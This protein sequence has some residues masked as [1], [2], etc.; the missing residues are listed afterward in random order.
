MIVTGVTD[1]SFRAAIDAYGQ[2]SCQRVVHMRTYED[3]SESLPG[4]RARKAVIDARF[5]SSADAT[6]LIRA[7]DICAF[8]LTL[9]LIVDLSPRELLE[10]PR[11]LEAKAHVR[12]V[13]PRLH[14]L[15][16]QLD[17]TGPRG[18]PSATLHILRSI[19]HRVPSES[20]TLTLA[21]CIMGERPATIPR[22][23]RGIGLS[24]EAA[25]RAWPVAEHCSRARQKALIRIGHVVH[26]VENDATPDAA[27]TAGGFKN[28][29][30]FFNYVKKHMGRS[31]RS[32]MR[33]GGFVAVVK[34]IES[35]FA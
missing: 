20:R 27:A 9:F 33:A 32:V 7:L 3:L 6:D 4:S 31:Y 5:W 1:T 25:A 29:R 28:A 26:R 2:R 14:D 8:E 19:W 21:L 10:L 22:I 17:G 16:Q 34:E 23:C 24:R 15:A 13:C 18:L 35:C 30:C 12:L 11:F